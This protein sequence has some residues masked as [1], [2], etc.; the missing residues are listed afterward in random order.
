MTG[1]LHYLE[2][3]YAG[4]IE[5]AALRE[6]LNTEGSLWIDRVNVD[7]AELQ[8]ARLSGIGLIRNAP[9]PGHSLSWK[10]QAPASD[11]SV[12]V[13]VSE[14]TPGHI[15]LIAYNLDQT[16]VKAL[17]TG[18]EIDP[19]KWEMTQDSAT[20]TI[21]FERGRDVEVTFAP[22]AT[23]T[24]ELRLVT[25]GVPYWSRPDLGIDPE[26]VRVE[27]SRM[28]V[29]VHSLGAVDAPASRVVLRDRAGRVLAT[30]NVPPLKAPSDLMP[31]TADAALD[32]P[33]N[34]DWHGGAVTVE[35]SSADP[36]IT[37]RNNR[38]EL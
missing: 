7:N 28:T 31:N 12:A 8:R 6:Y 1:D 10:F 23:T 13:A 35:M 36:E 17:M 30:A 29:K 32:L 11:Q 33:A 16:P 21:D 18:W 14:A 22:R 24:I 3:L 27:G 5:A 26:D 38:V 37:L 15:K 34:T 4:Q 19:G 9:Y 20:R 2:Q 25:K